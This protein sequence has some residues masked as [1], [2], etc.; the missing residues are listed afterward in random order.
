[1]LPAWLAGCLLCTRLAGV[2]PAEASERGSRFAARILLR[3]LCDEKRGRVCLRVRDRSREIQPKRLDEASRGLRNRVV[4]NARKSF[5]ASPEV[6]ASAAE[7][8][9]GGEEF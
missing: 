2:E 5:C 8:R 9:R 3:A 7:A 4:R 1:M 6:A